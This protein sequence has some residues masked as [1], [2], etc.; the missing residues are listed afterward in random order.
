[1]KRF[2]A[3]FA[4]TPREQRLV[5]FVIVALVVGTW[6]KNSRDMRAYGNAEPSPNSSL[7]SPTPNER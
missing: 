1:M 2:L 7:V 5:V 4:L 6:I 3:M